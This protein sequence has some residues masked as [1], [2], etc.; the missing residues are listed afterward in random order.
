MSN[1][2]ASISHL[3]AALPMRER[4][5]V[6]VDHWD[7]DLFAIGVAHRDDERRLVYVSTFKRAPG[8]YDYQCEAPSGPDATDFETTAAGDDV[9]F[10]ELVRAMVLHLSRRTP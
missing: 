7:A 1:K 2:D 10:E 4:L 9:G 3:V 6:L 5:W 8:R